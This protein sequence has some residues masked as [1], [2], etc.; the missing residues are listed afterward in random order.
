MQEGSH[1]STHWLW[2][3]WWTL[4]LQT[5]FTVCYYTSCNFLLIPHIDVQKLLQT[6]QGVTLLPWV[7]LNVSKCFS[8]QLTINPLLG[9]KKKNLQHL[10]VLGNYLA[11]SLL[12]QYTW[13]FKKCASLVTA[14]CF[15]CSD[16]QTRGIWKWRTNSQ[17][18]YFV[19][20]TSFF[21][22]KW[23]MDNFTL[24]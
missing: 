21:F 3:E 18:Y 2:R 5:Y 6:H 14:N 19:L 1:R 11:F 7:K 17:H 16:L 9:V 4:S 20:R 10:A 15:S 8:P 24:C 23:K 13:F 22:L 12:K